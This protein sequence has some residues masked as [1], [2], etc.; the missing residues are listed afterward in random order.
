VTEPLGPPPVPPP[1]P[2]EAPR[3]VIVVG[4]PRTVPVRL[5]L[6]IIGLIYA[7]RLSVDVAYDLRRVITLLVISVFFAII[8]SPAVAFFERV[9]FRRSIATLLVFVIALAV[10]AGV[11]YLISRPL[12]DAAVRFA[13]DLPDMVDRARHGKGQIGHLIRRYHLENWAEDNSARLQNA[14]SH[15]GGPAVSTIKTLLSG[16]AGLATLLVVSFLVLLEAPKL[17]GAFLNTLPPQRA[18]RVRR[19]AADAAKSVTGYVI[20]NMATSFIAGIVVYVT[21]RILHVPFASVFGVWVAF[22][23]LLPLVGG[24]LAG[25]PTVIVASIHSIPAGVTTLIVFLIYQQVENHALNP[26]IMSKTVNLNPLWVMLSVLVGAELSGFVGA[27]LA[28]PI[29]GAIQVV[30]RDVWDER[31]GQ[32]K[33]TPTV[34]AG[35]EPVQ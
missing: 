30:A 8:L 28:I 9:G 11:V 10:L 4:L 18:E 16:L 3:R 29:A 7:A 31:R 25:V 14:L 12:Y 27:L 26:M 34:G 13:H 22:V 15:A 5:V 2:P 20:G 23:D 19:V 33:E 24:L 1:V 32:M 17:T 35:G 21:L 6:G